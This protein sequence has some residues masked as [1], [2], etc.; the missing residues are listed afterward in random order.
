MNRP[1]AQAP[2]LPGYRYARLLGR[3][4]FADVFLYSD[5]QLGGREVAVK[6][7]HDGLTREEGEGFQGEAQV[8]AKLSNHPSIVTIYQAGTTG[9]GRPFLVMENCQD[10]HLG[11][12]IER[13]PMRVDRVLTLAIQLAGAVESAHRLGI[14]HR[15]IKPANVLFNEF[16]RAALTDFGIAATTALAAAGSAVGMSV[17]WAPPEQLSRGQAMMASS[18]VYSLAATMWHAL[19]GRS[20]FAVAGGDNSQLAVASRVRSQMPPRT[21]REDVPESLERVL[22]Q[23]MAKRSDERYDS[24][25]DFARALQSVQAELRHGTTPIEVRE[26]RDADEIDADDEPSGTHVAAFVPIDPSGRGAELRSG[27][28]GSPRGGLSSRLNRLAPVPQ[29]RDQ[30]APAAFTG[31]SIPALSIDDTVSGSASRE[32]TSSE[33]DHAA[34]VIPDRG[35]S[36]GPRLIAAGL[37]LVVGVALATLTL[38]GTDATQSDRASDLT[39]TPAAADAVGDTVPA[40][41]GVRLQ[42]DRSQVLVTWKNR[43]PADGDTY[44]VRVVD[45]ENPQKFEV[46]DSTSVTL[47]SQPGRTCVEIILRRSNGRGSLPSVECTQEDG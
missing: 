18:D 22:Q 45:P 1:P 19:V 44:L 35:R 41:S 24:A 43:D 36:W 11:L 17:P 46:V 34:A 3:G 4:G 5:L 28:S 47:P 30:V 2:E 25:V 6:V 13:R 16:G 33:A 15:D 14:L 39:P 12:R 27:G 8:M 29:Q 21:A 40:V 37:V 38:R 31:H 32:S 7:M 10:R 26:D 20:P 42:G 9:D 23:A